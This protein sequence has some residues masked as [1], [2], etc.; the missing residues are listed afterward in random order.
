MISNYNYSQQAK[1]AE[2]VKSVIDREMA[3]IA[4]MRTNSSKQRY[5]NDESRG[6]GN[7]ESK[8]ITDDDENETPDYE[9]LLNVISDNFNQLIATFYQNITS[10]MIGTSLARVKESY[11]EII[12]SIVENLS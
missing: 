3:M 5:Q 7:F 6:S 11:E 2:Q 10:A 8:E 4:V 12:N 1:V 9:H